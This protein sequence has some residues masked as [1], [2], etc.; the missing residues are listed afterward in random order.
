MKT[1]FCR[2][3]CAL[4]LMLA[5][6]ALRGQSS[7]PGAAASAAN[8]SAPVGIQ[9]QMQE[10][11]QELRAIRQENQELKERLARLEQNQG[12]AATPAPPPPPPQAAAAKETATPPPWAE[13]L[14]KNFTPFGEVGIRY[15]GLFNHDGLPGHLGDNFY[16]RPE[17]MVRLG[18]KGQIMPRL[19]YVIRL[20]SGISTEGGDPWMAFADPGDRR[21][22]GFDEYYFTWQ[23]YAG[24]TFNSFMFGGKLANVPAALGTTELIVDKDFGLH[25]FANLSSY[26]VT[27]KTTFSL[28]SSLG[29]VTNGGANGGRFLQ[30]VVNGLGG[31]INDINQ[32]GAPRANAYVAQIRGDH[33]LSAST[34]LHGS[35]GLVNISNPNDVPLF[36]GATGLLVPSSGIGG[37]DG[38]RVPN[39][40]QGTSTNMPKILPLDQN[41]FVDITGNALAASLVINGGASAFHI[42]DTFGSVTLHADKKYPIRLFTDFSDNLGAGAYIFG[43]ANSTDIS[44]PAGVKRRAERGRFGLVSGFDIGSESTVHASFFSYKFVLIGSEATLTYV[45]NDQWHTNVRGH[46]FTW[47]YRVSPNVAPF[48]T[49][50]VAQNYDARLIGFSSLARYPTSNLLPGMDPWMFRPRTGV[51]VT[52]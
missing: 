25:L 2:S 43:P 11:A 6:C 45:N 3:C 27:D 16:N 13:N 32:Y 15:Q 26:K 51:L 36:L 39:M 7:A 22:V 33:A 38:L 37:I 47:Q 5:P 9:D 4:L 14:M 52:F 24:K 31:A 10:L 1:I 29:F 21:F 12:A 8:S 50:M 19:S 46:D 28:L 34:H 23:P 44:T 48:F 20:S 17:G 41:G 30:P 40:P 49:L 42:L 18:L 35:F